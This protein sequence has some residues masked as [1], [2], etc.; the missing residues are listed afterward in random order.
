MLARLKSG[1]DRVELGTQLRRTAEGAYEGLDVKLFFAGLP[2][3]IHYM[4]E[5]IMGD[6][7]LLTP[8]VVAL[9]ALVLGLFYRRLSGVLLPLAGVGFAVVWSMG[10]M[11]LTDT[12][13]SILT[14]VLPVILVAVGSAYA[15]HMV[16]R[17]LEERRETKDRREA[18]RRAV[19][20]VGLAVIMTGLTTMVGFGSLTSANVQI[21]RELGF[22]A[23]FG[24][25]GATVIA[26]TLVPVVLA[27]IGGSVKKDVVVRPL[28]PGRVAHATARFI[29]RHTRFIS[30]GALVLF[31]AGVLA[32]PYVKREVNLVEFFSE[33][34]TMRS[35]ERVIEEHFGGSVPMHIY[36]QGDIR[37]P[38]VLRR[39]ER[40]EKQ[41]RTEVGRAAQS[42][43]ALL[44]ELGHNLYDERRI[45]PTRAGVNELFYL[46]EGN[47]LLKNL[48]AKGAYYPPSAVNGLINTF[49]VNSQ[50]DMETTEEGLESEAV[51]ISNVPSSQTKEM[52]AHTEVMEDFLATGVPRLESPVI[53][54]DLD[55]VAFDALRDYQL[56]WIS[57]GLSRDAIYRG[58]EF[59]QEEALNVLRD[60]GLGEP[61]RI[62]AGTITDVLTPWVENYV[63]NSGDVLL[64]DVDDLADLAEAITG[65]WRPGGVLY[66]EIE[67]LSSAIENA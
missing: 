37:H 24:I 5:T 41:M 45:P 57:W 49:L 7:G 30:L 19:S 54:D 44:R 50:T 60:V 34:S 21:I 63:T 25:F 59:G 38:S 2:F 62:A 15:I 47:D 35:S 32:L 23:A 18:V 12:P 65:V 56:E 9:L 13:I 27:I 33:E 3:Q 67:D 29:E 46:I 1:V 6:M 20:H 39:M 51:I 31:V 11:A 66:P 36:V 14:G 52:I 16:S 8:I 28:E 58:L 42:V 26:L 43:G 17:Y 55:G 4:T 64:D 10:L 61:A 48:S 22:F 53:V 40:I